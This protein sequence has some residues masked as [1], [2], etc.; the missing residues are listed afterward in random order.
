MPRLCVMSRIAMPSR[1]LSSL[2]QFQNLRLNRHV[3]RGGRFVRH[4]QFRL[5]RQRHRNHHPLLHAAGHLERI[6]F[7]ARFRRRNADQFQQ[8]NDFLVGRL[9]RA[10]QL[11]RFLDLVADA[12]NRIQRRARFLENV[13]DHAAANV[14]QF[15]RSTFSGRRWPFS[16]ISPP[17]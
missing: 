8:P 14:T 3:Q 12:E 11:Q 6:I 16:K 5:A 9:F 1:C 17:T 2:Q 13:T 7:D 4:E 10:M 15:A